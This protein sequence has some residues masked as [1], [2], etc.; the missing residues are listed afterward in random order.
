MC[1]FFPQSAFIGFV[2]F[3][4]LATIIYLDSINLFI[5]VMNGGVLDVWAELINNIYMGLDF[6]WLMY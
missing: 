4:E 2:Y 3:S 5:F 1:T 6:R